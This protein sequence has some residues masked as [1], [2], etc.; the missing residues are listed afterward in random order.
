MVNNEQNDRNGKQNEKIAVFH[1]VLKA[2]I[3]DYCRSLACD[4]QNLWFFRLSFECFR[5]QF[6]VISKRV[7]CTLA[8]AGPQF[9]H[10]RIK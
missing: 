4:C 10:Q 7:Q 2:L 3:E 9:E 5:L 6:F 1:F 8:L